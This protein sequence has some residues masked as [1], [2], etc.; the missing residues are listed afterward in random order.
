MR[1]KLILMMF[2][3]LLLVQCQS[4]MWNRIT[5]T[6]SKL[7]TDA[8]KIMLN[9]ITASIDCRYGFDP[10]LELDYIFKAGK[11]SDQEIQAKAPGMK[12]VLAKY[13]SE[14]IINFYG[15][16]VHMRDAQVSEMNYYRQDEE[17]EDATY[18]QKYLLPEAELFLDILEKNMMQVNPSYSEAINKIKTKNILK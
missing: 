14:E 6:E 9:E 13:K 5:K 18:I 10:D 1:T 8:E 17:W 12:K 3:T 11:M 15:K 2:L 7:Y 16:I 4:P